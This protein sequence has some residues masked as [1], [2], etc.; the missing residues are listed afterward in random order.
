MPIALRMPSPFIFQGN[1]HGLRREFSRHFNPP[2]KLWTLRR[3]LYALKQEGSTLDEYATELNKLT[4]QLRIDPQTKLDLFIQGLDQHLKSHLLLKQ[5]ANFEQALRSA[6]LKASVPNSG[7]TF[8]SS[9]L[10]WNL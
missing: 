1:Y 8:L 10:P 5:P 4:A 9:S 3:K 2:E 6:R 7:E